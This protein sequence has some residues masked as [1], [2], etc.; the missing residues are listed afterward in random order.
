MRAEEEEL[1]VLEVFLS[2]SD[3]HIVAFTGVNRSNGCTWTVSRI[4][5]RLSDHVTGKVCVIDAN[6]RWPALHMSMGVANTSGL[7]QAVTQDDPIKNFARQVG[8][9]NLWVVPAGG[10]VTDS[11]RRLMDPRFAVRLRE[12]AR[13]F[14]YVL[15]DAPAI[16]ASADARLLARISDGVVMVIEANTTRR[17][18]AESA[19]KVL[20][21]SKTPIL[22]AI[23][24]KRTYPIPDHIYR[25]L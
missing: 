12:L 21:N 6:L 14:D 22:G 7:L 18:S 11:H 17:D 10:A 16:N 4:A 2:G 3:N 13:E 9:T 24:D 20:E 15:I 25:R 5:R 19:K 23:L 1:R 8:D